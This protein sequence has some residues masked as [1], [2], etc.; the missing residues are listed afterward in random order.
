[1]FIPLDKTPLLF[2]LKH[3]FRRSGALE[4]YAMSNNTEGLKKC[5]MA[6]EDNESLSK[7][8]TT[9]PRVSKV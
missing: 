7:L 2:H 3:L 9:S 1:M 4:Y 8:F 6:L 5:Y